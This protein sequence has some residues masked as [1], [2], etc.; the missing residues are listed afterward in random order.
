MLRFLES[1]LFH[2]N[3]FY[4]STV[5][6]CVGHDVTQAMHAMQSLSRTGT[7]FWLSGYSGKSLSSKTFTGQTSAHT[8]SPLHLLQSTFT[9]GTRINLIIKFAY[10]IINF[11]YSLFCLATYFL[12]KCPKI[13]LKSL[14]E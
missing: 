1:M 8:P 5:I 3:W 14:R 7:D 2:V 9:F 12:G 13:I 10:Y 4:S 11:C 6:A